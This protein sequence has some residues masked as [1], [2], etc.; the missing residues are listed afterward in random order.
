M[1]SALWLIPAVVAGALAGA[2]LF[3]LCMANDRGEGGR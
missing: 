2:L 1:I 3:A